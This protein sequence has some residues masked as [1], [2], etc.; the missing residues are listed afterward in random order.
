M[1]RSEPDKDTN[2]DGPD[3]AGQLLPLVYAEL[4]ELARRKM[5]HEP[6]GHTM[7]TTDLVHEAYVRLAASDVKW[8][9]RGHFFG[10]AAQAMR[11]ILIERARRYARPKHGGGQRQV[12][13]DAAEIAAPGTGDDVLAIDEALKRLEQHDPIRSTVV[14][15]RYFAG[16][17][18]D[19]TARVLELAPS[20]VSGHWAFA[21]AW[22][23][24]EIRSRSGES[25][26]GSG[27]S[28]AP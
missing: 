24:E 6:A 3:T 2:A 8:D 11:R 19:Q 22:L 28:T 7:Q 10:A 13:L 12:D 16:L 20:T 25:G 4:R 9:N 17:T 14:S 23:F 1:N 18:I 26:G 21:R 27:G 5:C 15:L